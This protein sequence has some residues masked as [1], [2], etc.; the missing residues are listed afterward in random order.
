MRQKPHNQKTPQS[1]CRCKELPIG[2]QIRDQE[3]YAEHLY[4][5]AWDPNSW[6]GY[7]ICPLTG[8]VWQIV[9]TG[10]P[11]VAYWDYV[12]TA[13]QQSSLLKH[14]VLEGQLKVFSEAHESADFV[15]P[16]I[17][18]RVPLSGLIRQP[19]KVETRWS[20]DGIGMEGEQLLTLWMYLPDPV[21]WGEE[22]SVWFASPLE[23]VSASVFRPGQHLTL[24]YFLG[25]KVADIGTIEVIDKRVLDVENFHQTFGFD[26]SYSDVAEPVWT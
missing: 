10:N 21:G 17:V 13:Y 14:T 11:R 2:T 4:R 9:Y 18:Y 20:V 24:S 1:L 15:S 7:S 16:K 8:I 5:V 12:R 26:K 3:S 22:G 6:G 19:I 25:V 23:A